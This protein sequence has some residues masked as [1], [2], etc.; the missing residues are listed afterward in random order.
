MALPAAALLL[1]AAVAARA[2]GTE[3]PPTPSHCGNSSWTNAACW[4]WDPTDAT[5]AL[6]SAIN[7]KAS[8]VFVPNMNG[9]AWNVQPIVVNTSVAGGQTI[10]LEAG[11]RIVALSGS[12]RG[13]GDSLLSVVKAANLRLV[14]YGAE[15][16]MRRDEYAKPPYEASPFRMGINI[17][18]ATNISLE[19][20]RVTNTG[21]DGIY[22]G[23][24]DSHVYAD[25]HGV[26][27]RD[28]TVVNASRCG[29]GITG[30]V[31]LLVQNV[32]VSD[33][34]GASP[35]SAVDIEPGSKYHHAQGIVFDN[36]TLQK[37]GSHNFAISLHG[38]ESPVS[39]T[40]NN[41]RLLDGRRGGFFF[42]YIGE[43]QAGFIR[44]YNSS[45]GKHEEGC[46]IFEH[47]AVAPALE[48]SMEKTQVGPG[49]AYRGEGVYDKPIFFNAPHGDTGVSL[50]LSLSLC[51]S[52]SL[53][54]SLSPSLTLAS[55]RPTGTQ[56]T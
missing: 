36:V 4:G 8:T 37:S 19:G 22:I 32:F 39:I 10:L 25:S 33:T 11:V 54:L 29:L 47:K 38:V 2:G 27:V 52:V 26:T 48:F 45:V 17:L 55:T 21:G 41:T 49:C 51:L 28:V 44:V 12:F 50:S 23:P 42:V 14:G 46:V 40:L 56:G 5:H 7:S 15:L 3:S 43:A 53:S 30:V 13:K 6:Q 16:S 31:G 24:A 9:T 18:G 1:S 34:H 20:I 35:E